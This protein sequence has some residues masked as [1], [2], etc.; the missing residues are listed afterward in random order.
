MELAFEADFD[1]Y[2]LDSPAGVLQE[3]QCPLHAMS[4]PKCTGTCAGLALKEVGEARD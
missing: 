1:G 3:L 2:L 4:F